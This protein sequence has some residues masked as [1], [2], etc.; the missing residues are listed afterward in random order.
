MVLRNGESGRRTLRR[1]YV[2]FRVNWQSIPFLVLAGLGARELWAVRGAEGRAGR[3]L[4]R[5]LQIRQ[6]DLYQLDHVDSALSSREKFVRGFLNGAMSRGSLDRWLAVLDR[7]QA[8]VDGRGFLAVALAQ[9]AEKSL[10][11]CFVTDLWLRN[12]NF[13]RAV[14]RVSTNWESEVMK[15]GAPDVTTRGP[16]L[17]FPVKRLYSR[18]SSVLSSRLTAETSTPHS[19]AQDDELVLPAPSF[20]QPAEAESLLVLNLGLAYGAMYSYDYLL[21]FDTGSCLH[22][23]RTMAVAV[24]GGPNHP[25]G[26]QVS[27]PGGKFPLGGLQAVSRLAFEFFGVRSRMDYL[28]A[29]QLLQLKRQRD[30]LELWLTELPKLKRVVFAYDMQAPVALAWACARLGIPTFAANERPASLCNASQP[31]AVETLLTA[32]DYFSDAAIR[33]PTVKIR[34]ARAMGMWR[35][36]LVHECRSYDLPSE[37][38]EAPGDG[39]K[40]AL[41]LPYGRKTQGRY[42]DPFATALPAVR[43]FINSMERLAGDHSD[44][45]FVFRGKTPGWFYDDALAV[46][47]QTLRDLPNVIF[48]QD[49]GRLLGSYRLLAHCDFVIAKYTSLVDEALAL[50]VPCLVHDFVGNS[51]GYAQQLAPHLPEFVFTKNQGDLEVKF[52]RLL[53]RNGFDFSEIWRPFGEQIYGQWNDGHVRQ[54][55]RKAIEGDLGGECFE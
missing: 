50:G 51:S 42:L 16:L 6:V 53:D 36:D 22:P 43:H 25:E 18:L 23:S 47:L 55:I 27:L 1:A 3:F 41:V 17:T 39:R 46:E 33:S 15:S 34:E 5:L 32:S 12:Q 10:Q 9:Q 31:F 19:P 4:E 7:D 26:I 44:V 49:Y 21:S 45:L 20:A 38:Q 28:V 14:V 54:R 48:S 40:L 11:P 13:D 8:S 35:T 30:S 37:I 52:K 29:T 24:G 2:V